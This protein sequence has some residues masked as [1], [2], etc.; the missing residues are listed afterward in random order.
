MVFFL[1]LFFT[2]DQPKSAWKQISQ[3][4]ASLSSPGTSSDVDG[5]KTSDHTSPIALDWLFQHTDSESE[6]SCNGPG[7]YF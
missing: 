3:K 6:K 4:I 5:S 2:A 7:I 1:C